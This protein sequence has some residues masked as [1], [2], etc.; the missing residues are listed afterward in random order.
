LFGQNR[1]FK[2]LVP[3]PPMGGLKQVGIFILKI[4]TSKKNENRKNE[5]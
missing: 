5:L 3:H 2:G 4:L 1:G